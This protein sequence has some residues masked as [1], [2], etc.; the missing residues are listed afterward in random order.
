MAGSFS[1]SSENVSDRRLSGA[2]QRDRGFDQ[3]FEG[4]AIE[5]VTLAQ[6]NRAARAGVKAGVEQSLRIVERGAPREGQLDLVLVS[7]AGAD[8]AVVLPHRDA[9]GVRRLAPLAGLGDA[10][11]RLADQRADAVESRRAPVAGLAQWSDRFGGN[12]QLAQ[13]L[14]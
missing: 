2:V 8:D 13:P 14:A 12:S 7:L 3:R 10:R 6:V 9:G 5:S 11:N 4:R 1:S